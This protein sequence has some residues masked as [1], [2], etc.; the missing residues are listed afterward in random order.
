MKRHQLVKRSDDNIE[1][2]T[3]R[4]NLY[5]EET[6]PLIDYYKNDNCLYVVDG[7]SDKMTIFNRIV[8]ILTNK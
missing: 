2:F 5:L 6:K 4:F 8:E 7:S 3:K 1:T